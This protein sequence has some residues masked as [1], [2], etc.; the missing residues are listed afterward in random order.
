MTQM[1]CIHCGEVFNL[2]DISKPIH[3]KW[4]DHNKGFGFVWIAD[5]CPKCHKGID[6]WYERVKE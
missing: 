6:D 4:N 3:E 2:E 5:S 1:R